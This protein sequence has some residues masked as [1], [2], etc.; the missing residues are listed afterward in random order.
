VTSTWLKLTARLAVYLLAMSL[1]LGTAIFGVPTRYYWWMRYLCW[2]AGP[3]SVECWWLDL[4]EYLDRP[5][6]GSGRQGT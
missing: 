1:I 6:E 2:R 3:D 4:L 5:R